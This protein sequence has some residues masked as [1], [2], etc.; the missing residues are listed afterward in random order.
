M[1]GRFVR[2]SD[3]QRVAEWMQAHDTGVFDDS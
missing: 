3:K 2:R 1:C